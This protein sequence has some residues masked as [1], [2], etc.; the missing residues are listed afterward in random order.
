[1]VELVEENTALYDVTDSGYSRKDKID[2]V[3]EYVSKGSVNL[4]CLYCAL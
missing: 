1:M 3:C 4:R 2:Q